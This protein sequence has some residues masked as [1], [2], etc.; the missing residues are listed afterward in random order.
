MVTLQQSYLYGESFQSFTQKEFPRTILGPVQHN[1]T[2]EM[3]TKSLTV[4]PG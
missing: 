3:T 2:N 1:E 4:D